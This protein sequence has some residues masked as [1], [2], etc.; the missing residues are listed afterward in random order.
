MVQVSIPSCADGIVIGFDLTP[1][2][3]KD[4]EE[5]KKRHIE[6]EVRVK[7]P[8]GDALVEVFDHVLQRERPVG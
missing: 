4:E 3:I 8:N 2:E 6:Q 7:M 1:R 5:D